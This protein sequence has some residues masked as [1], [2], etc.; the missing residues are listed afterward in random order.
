MI[1]VFIP[2]APA[3]FPRQ[4]NVAGAFVPADQHLVAF[5]TEFGRET[6]GLTSAICE[7]SRCFRWH[8]ELSILS[9]YLSRQN[10]QSEPIRYHQ[11]SDP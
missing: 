3:G 8:I 2:G 10:P 9:I 5:E 4:N 1:E 6:D 7:K 11:G